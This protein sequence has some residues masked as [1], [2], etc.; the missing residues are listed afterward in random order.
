MT[1]LEEL[2]QDCL[3]EYADV[4]KPSAINDIQ[5]LFLEHEQV[6]PASPLTPGIT[7]PFSVQSAKTVNL[8][9]VQNRSLFSFESMERL[10]PVTPPG[11]S[12]D[13]RK[14]RFI[15]VECSRSYNGKT[16]LKRHQRKHNQP[17][18][19]A[20]T[21]VGC[22]KTFYRSDAMRAHAKAHERRLERMS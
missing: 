15:C 9:Y 4:Y 13:P 7:V 22:I 19:Y 10:S 8:A 5:P 3:R 18:K 2:I 17:N 12:D 6:S 16:E 20:C 1:Y 14:D 21:I 11:A